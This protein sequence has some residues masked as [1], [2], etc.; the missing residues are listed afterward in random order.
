MKFVQVTHDPSKRG[1][2]AYNFSLP[3]SVRLLYAQDPLRCEEWKKLIL[4]FD[5]KLLEERLVS[6]IILI[7]INSSLNIHLLAVS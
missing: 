4:D 5:S 3:N 1:V 7:G 2:Q 6:P